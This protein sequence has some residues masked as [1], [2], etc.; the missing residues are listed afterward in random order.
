MPKGRKPVLIKQVVK[1]VLK[2]LNPD[3][4]ES[5]RKFWEASAGPELNQHTKPTSLRKGRLTIEVENSSWLYE[6]TVRHKSR[7]F[8]ELQGY[9]GEK[10]L[11]ELRFRL[12][13]IN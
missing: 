12:G 1:K 13:K 9:L 4:K 2:E 5:L 6:I 10:K 8:K 11:K 7:L 3:N